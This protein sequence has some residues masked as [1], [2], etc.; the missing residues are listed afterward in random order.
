LGGGRALQ[1]G[2][3][4]EAEECIM[5]RLVLSIAAVG[6]AGVLGISNAEEVPT[7]LFG[8]LANDSEATRTM[9]IGPGTKHVNVTQGD[10]VKFVVDGR[11]FTFRFANTSTRTFDLQRVAPEGMLNHSVT[12]FVA[13]SADLKGGP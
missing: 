6:L 7:G 8:S 5:T 1:G 9:A 2:G 4:R 13:I 3:Q 10:V 11:Q 12:A